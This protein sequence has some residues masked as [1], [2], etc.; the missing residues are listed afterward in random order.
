MFVNPISVMVRRFI[1]RIA[2]RFKVCFAVSFLLQ[3]SLRFKAETRHVR[4][5]MNIRSIREW[6]KFLSMRKSLPFPLSF[7]IRQGV[8]RVP[9]ELYTCYASYIEIFYVKNAVKYYNVTTKITKFIYLSLDFC[10]LM[11]LYQF[12]KVVGMECSDRMAVHW[13]RREGN[14]E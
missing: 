13:Q 12:Q 8:S 5:E 4:R 9:F 7:F 11:T 6:K 1:E 14:Q 3:W 2:T 10:Y